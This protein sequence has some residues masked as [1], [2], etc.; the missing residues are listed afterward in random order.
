[1]HT[2]ELSASHTEISHADKLLLD[3]ADKPRI[4]KPTAAM[5][6]EDD[7][8]DATFEDPRTNFSTEEYDND[9]VE[10]AVFKLEEIKT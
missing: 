9:R 6:T 3:D 1:L 8:V 2:T 5:N 10:I 4:P 7:P